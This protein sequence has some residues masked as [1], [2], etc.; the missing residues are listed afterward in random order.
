MTAPTS[1][2][3]Y[4][5]MLECEWSTFV[6]V[7]FEAAGLVRREG[8]HHAGPEASMRIMAIHARHCALRNAVLERTLKLRQYIPM[9]TGALLIYS[10][11]F[12]C[13]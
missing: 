6:P 9:A 5:R 10:G 8:L 4:G 13:D 2:K 7:A 1:L 12:S 3:P 11:R